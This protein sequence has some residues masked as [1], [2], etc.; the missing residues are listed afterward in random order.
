MDGFPRETAVVFKGNFLG[1]CHGFTSLFPP[2]QQ[3][4]ASRDIIGTFSPQEWGHSERTKENVFVNPV[5][6]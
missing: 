6:R 5:E 3:E 1:G 4:R 2:T